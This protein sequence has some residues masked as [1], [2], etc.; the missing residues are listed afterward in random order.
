MIR[1]L[2]CHLPKGTSETFS[3]EIADIPADKW[4][5]WAAAPGGERGD[6]D[7]DCEKVPGDTGAIAAANDLESGAGWNPARS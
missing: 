3:A 5:S 4:V 2:C 1:G 6:A 7:F